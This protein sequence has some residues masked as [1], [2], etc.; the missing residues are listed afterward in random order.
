MKLELIEKA[1]I[2]A[3][4][5]EIKRRE[6]N[7][8]ELHAGGTADALKDVVDLVETALTRAANPL[9]PEGVPVKQ[10]ADANGITESAVY[11]RIRNNQLVAKKGPGGWRILQI[12]A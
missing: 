2:A 9:L 8:R 5:E 12:S 3:A 4:L 7:A 10:Y 6:G 1:P 11:K